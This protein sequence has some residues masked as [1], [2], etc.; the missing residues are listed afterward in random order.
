MTDIDTERVRALLS[1]AFGPTDGLAVALSDANQGRGVFSAVVRA[2]LGPD[3]L[4]PGR[5]DRV[6]VKFPAAGPNGDAARLSGA[7]AREALAYRHVLARSQVLA[8]KAH[9]VETNPDGSAAFVLE[10]LGHHRAVDQLNGL[11][12]D[13]GV[14]VAEA[15]SRF[16]HGWAEGSR[17]SGLDVR[18]STPSTLDPQAL[19]RG[20]DAV[21]TRW[22]DDLDGSIPE[23]FASVFERRDELV[24]AFGAAPTPTL[25]HGDPRADNLVFNRDQLP[26]L[27]DWQQLAIQLGEADLAWLAA[28]S[29]DPETRRKADADLISAYGTSPDRYRLGFVLPGL[30]VLLLAQRQTTDPRSNRFIATSLDRIGAALVDLEVAA[31]NR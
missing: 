16:H 11:G 7:C 14:R 21:E 28:T 6:I 2:E 1:G 10:D 18:R 22:A 12:V 17:L 27:F 31:I 29:L 24:A 5:P 3:P 25:C 8:P 9:L 4:D 19:R 15:L 20:L 13:D 30:T 26:V 23:A